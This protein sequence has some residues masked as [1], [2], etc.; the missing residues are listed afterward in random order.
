MI[1]GR[2]MAYDSKH[3][4]KLMCCEVY[5]AEPA[6]PAFLQWSRSLI[7]FDRTD[8]PNNIPHLGRYLLIVDLIIGQEAAHQGANGWR[9]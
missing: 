2:T 8:H 7:T 5:A 4:Q 6:T 9:Y 3:L 1:F